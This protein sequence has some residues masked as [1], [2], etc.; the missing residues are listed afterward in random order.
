MIK[1]GQLA[2]DIQEH[3]LFLPPTIEGADLVFERQVRSIADL[4][5]WNEQR[6]LFRSLCQGQEHGR[7]F[8]AALRS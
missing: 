3:L 2:P 6:R 8:R 4:M 1:L 5:D 7:A